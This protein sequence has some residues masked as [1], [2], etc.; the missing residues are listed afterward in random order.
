MQNPVPAIAFDPI[1]PSEYVKRSRGETSLEDA[2]SRMPRNV[3]SN[4]ISYGT[5]LI[6]VFLIAP[7]LV[8]RLGNVSYGVWGLIGQLIEYSFLL[9]FGIRIAITRYVARHLVLGEPQEINRVV[10][11]G[12]FLS[13]FSAALALACGGIFAWGLPRFFPIPPGLVSDARWTVL[14]C[15]AS[16]AVSFP[17]SIFFGCVVA[18]SRYDL[19]SIRKCAPGVV[20]LLMLWILLKAGGSIVTVAVV[21]TLAIVVGYGLDF[22]FALRLFPHLRVRREFLERSTVKTLLHFSFYAFVISVA[23][24]LIFMTDNLVV[25]FALGPVAVAFYTVGMQLPAMLRESAGNITTIY[26]PLAYQMHALDQQASLRR[27]FISGSRVAALFI[28]PGVLGLSILGPRFLGLWMGGPFVRASGPI[29]ILLS[30]EALFY[31]LS[32][33]GTQVLYGMN[34]PKVNAW[35]SAGNAAA[36]LALSL[37]LVRWL[38]AVGVAWGTV[39]PAFLVEGIIFP[40]Y[41]ARLLGVAWLR[42]YQ[43]AV[44]GPLVLGVPYGLWLWFW[45]EQGLVRGYPSLV[46][47]VGSGL[48]LYAFLAWR[49]GM[50]GEERTWLWQRLSSGKSALAA[51]RP[52]GEPRPAGEL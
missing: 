8:H 20:R 50:D 46:L 25:G 45:Q 16:I 41:T 49:F 12:L 48:V 26:A 15:S 32:F 14:L 11:S 10:T 29:L 38:G 44:L 47:A 13:S 17:G 51:S 27:L 7:L 33:T 23:Y 42:F 24:R 22:I 21:T 43:S 30:V 19:V 3:L 2:K 1:G 4:W 40:L 28:L 37:V 34:R 6:V 31:T 36:N 35:L 18:H 39:I 9:D 5:N 52:A